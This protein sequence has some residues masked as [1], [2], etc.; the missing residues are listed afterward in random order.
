MPTEEK[1]WKLKNDPVRYEAEKKRKAKESA[2]FRLKHPFK[3]I[4]HRIKVVHGDTDCR[5]IDLFGICK[6]Q[7]CRCAISGRKLTC[8]NISIDHIIPVSKGGSNNK[9]N[10]QLAVKEANTAKN[11]LTLE[12]LKNLCRDI[13]NQ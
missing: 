9:E 1:Y 4:I 13:L 2:A 3:K 6:R 11:S 5:A 7:R 8:E 12:E 10:L